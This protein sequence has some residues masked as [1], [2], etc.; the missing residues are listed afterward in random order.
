VPI[1]VE[2]LAVSSLLGPGFQEHETDF[3]LLGDPERPDISVG[4]K[5]VVQ[6]VLDKSAI[7]LCL[8]LD[9]NKWSH[10][11]SSATS[12]GSAA[13]DEGTELEIHLVDQTLGRLRCVVT[14]DSDRLR[15][16]EGEN[17]VFVLQKNGGSG[18]VLADVLTVVLANVSAGGTGEVPV[19]KPGADGRESVQP[20][21]LLVEF[22]VEGLRNHLPA[23]R[24]INC[25]EVLV[26]T[27]IVVRRHLTNDHII[28]SG[29]RDGAVVDHRSD[30][31]AEVRA[32]TSG[33]TVVAEA[34]RH[35]HVQSTFNRCDTRVDSTYRTKGSSQLRVQD[36]IFDSTICSTY[37]NQT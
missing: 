8:L 11:V 36:I 22:K 32:N 21:R 10:E 6:P 3:G 16:L 23:G 20:R 2:G 33:S 15:C 17:V 28:D 4:E 26:L 35:I 18:T 37:P 7:L 1:D 13:S 31:A 5:S 9:S 30:V 19:T 12:A 34:T 27:K 14:K 25:W 24:G 29:L